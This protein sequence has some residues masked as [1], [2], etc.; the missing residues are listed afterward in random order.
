MP[1]KRRRQLVPQCANAFNST[2][3]SL[4]DLNRMKDQFLANCSHELKTPLV[5]GM[6]YVDLLLSGGM[7]PLESRQAKGLQIAYRN[8]E[9]LLGLI[10]NLLALAKGRFRPEA[11]KVAR[12]PLRPLLEECVESLKARARKTTS[13][14][15]LATTCV[16]ERAAFSF[17]T[18]TISSTRCFPGSSR[19]PL[20]ASPNR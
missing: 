2:S 14:T 13:W 10:E 15:A 8:L 12:F 5:S 6:G 18:T 4:R 17:T 1:L 19:A 20:P 9:R 7:G 11:L 16:A 3:L